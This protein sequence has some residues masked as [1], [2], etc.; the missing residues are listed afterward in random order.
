MWAQRGE[1]VQLLSGEVWESPAGV[2]GIAQWLEDD[3]WV[4]LAEPH[5]T[6][7]GVARMDVLPHSS[8]AICFTHAELFAW[9]DRNGWRK[10]NARIAL[11]VA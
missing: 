1:D 2:R 11:Q 6:G 9:F 7:Y 5:V 10:I 3:S 8:G 4:L